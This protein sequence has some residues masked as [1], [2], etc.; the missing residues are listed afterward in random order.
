M[1]TDAIRSTTL[2]KYLKETTEL[3]VSAAATERLAELV[4]AQLEQVA[5][6][7]RELALASERNTLLD[8]DIEEAFDGWLKDAG[9]S[10]LSSAALLTTIN[11]L[12]D[13]SLTELIQ[14]L[15]GQVKR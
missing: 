13:G 3:R 12:S 2:R 15:Q 11:G 7:A 10:L 6:R 8:R 4:K 5:G 9:P 1:A 14:E